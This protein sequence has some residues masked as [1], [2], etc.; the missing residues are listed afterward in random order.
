MLVVKMK[1]C[2]DINRKCFSCKKQDVVGCVE[3]IVFYSVLFDIV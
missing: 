1:Q 3:M 2:Y